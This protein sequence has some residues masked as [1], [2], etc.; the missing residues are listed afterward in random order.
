MNKGCGNCLYHGAS[1]ADK[2]G[3]RIFC[4][5]NTSWNKDIYSCEKWTEYSHHLTNEQRQNMATQ[6]K[7]NE[8][9]QKRH[10]SVLKAGEKDKIFQVKLCVLSFVF[11]IAATLISQWIWSLWNK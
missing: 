5:Y 2:N 3:A 1:K 8:E 6:L 9:N 11:G 4:M 7:E 10:N